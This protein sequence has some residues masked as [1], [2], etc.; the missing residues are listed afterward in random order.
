M[1]GILGLVAAPGKTVAIDLTTL[2]R[3]RDSMTV[4]G[5]DDAG[6]Y[7]KRNIAFGHRRLAIRDRDGGTQPWVDDQEQQVL[8]YNGEIY[9]DGDLRKEL[10]AVGHQ[11]YTRCDTEVLAH[12]YQEWGV[13][14]LAK[15]NGDFA[16]GLYDFT[17]DELL[18]ARDRCG[19]KPLF[20]TQIEGSLL[21]ASSIAA[22][23]AHP[24]FS[25]EPNPVALS[26]YLTT[27]RL[28]LG[29]ETMYKG[30]WQ[31]MPGEYLQFDGERVRIESYWD[32]PL[33]EQSS[34]RY[35]DAV[36][37]LE[38]LL[39][40]AISDRLVSD[41]PV[42]LFLSGGVDSSTLA[43]MLHRQGGKSMRSEC[44]G[45]L[46][47]QTEDFQY[48]RQCAD[49]VGFEHGEVKV[50]ADDYLRDWEYLIG[51]QGL[52]LSTPTDVIIYRLARE[53]KKSVGVALGGEGADELFCGYATQHWSAN[54]F[55]RAN[56][57][58]QNTNDIHAPNSS[59]FLQSMQRQ[60]GRVEFQSE[61]DHYLALNSLIPMQ[62]KPAL[63]Q[64]DIWQAAAQDQ[65]MVDHYHGQLEQWGDLPTRRKYAM[66]LHRVN[67]ESLLYRLDSATMQASLEARVPFTD[68]R[69]LEQGFRVP[70]RYKIDVAHGKKIP[71]LASAELD[72]Q[73][74][75]QSK[76]ILRTVAGRMMPAELAERRKA[77]FPT[78]VQSWLGGPWAKWAGQKLL[79]SPFANE[80]FQPSALA[81]ISAQPQQVGMWLWPMLNLS[82]WGDK[83]LA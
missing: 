23:V 31:L 13:E 11:F 56:R 18:L 59:N 47:P 73:N 41:V 51:E 33:Q 27:F 26:H 66:L 74:Y 62:V 19:V 54:D 3:M 17:K 38:E 22:I 7:F 9:N 32:Y 29:R 64:P 60:Y 46:D 58:Q 35:L 49:F 75:L 28:T 20:F 70:Q 14:T 42:G 36:D 37:E 43:C 45:S 8:V 52:P 5:P 72:Q 48:A 16:F 83:H 68:V 24:R 2:N 82:M 55:V 57:L 34:M 15:L 65:V 53:L 4:R 61:T 21:F 76:R 80:L 77:S 39:D 81:E 1:C 63:L 40:L 25:A 79:Q 30:I 10:E 50:S 6:S 69:L 44:G 78:S 12:A 71:H 67:L